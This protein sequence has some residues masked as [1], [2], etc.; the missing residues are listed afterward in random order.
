MKLE[1]LEGIGVEHEFALVDEEL[2]PQPIVDKIIKKMCGRIKN[3]VVFSDFI[4]SKELQAHVVE[5]KGTVP[6]TSP[7]IF[8]ETMHRGVIE[9]SDILDKFGVQLLG[10]GMHPTLKLNE[11]KVWSHRDKKIYEAFDHIFGL[12]QHGWLNIQSFQLNLS[13][14][15]ET[16]AVSIYN[17]LA[18]I[19]PYIPA[20]SAASPIYDSRF[21][22]YID[23]RLYFYKTNQKEVQSITGDIIPKY[24]ESFENYRDLTIRKYSRDLLKIGAPKILIGRNWINSRG[25]IIRFD[26]KAIEIRLIDEQECIKSDVALSCFIRSLL[27]G[28]LTSQNFEK[29]PHHLLVEDFNSTI[30]NG[31][32]AKVKSPRASTARKVCGN[33]NEIAYK[34]A[35]KEERKYL[36]II[37][38]R[39]EKGNLSQIVAEQVRKKM[40]RTDMKDAIHSVY[41]RLIKCLLKNQIFK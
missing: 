16:E 9:I 1:S 34:E 12:R 10:L 31:L 2:H 30:K 11:A 13:F 27:R 14:L 6:F 36:W 20:I 22:E 40:N 29:L 23:N 5:F 41:S 18:N 33:L 8:E 32:D 35:T 21:G 4:I 38:E 3:N 17:N 39:I 15:K 25:A 7:C 28:L 37:K 19:L 24:I 26:R